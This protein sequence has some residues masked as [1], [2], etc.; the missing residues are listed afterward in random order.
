[1]NLGRVVGR[2]VTTHK[3]SGLIGTTI[4]IIQPL[5]SSSRPLGKTILAA[6]SV[7]AGAGETII[8]VR[9][10]EASHAF[11]PQRVPVDAG[12]VGIVDQIFVDE[13]Q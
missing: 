5:D 7:G 10:R 2:V 11:V 1:M 13:D 4:L 9:G 12:I 6:D 3:D 8:F